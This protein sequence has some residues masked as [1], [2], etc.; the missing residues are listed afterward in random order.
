MGPEKGSGPKV[1]FTE[2]IPNDKKV[3][4]K[5]REFLGFT[6]GSEFFGIPEAKS[7]DS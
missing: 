2:L 7:I 1:R 3:K 5:T 6:R 4:K